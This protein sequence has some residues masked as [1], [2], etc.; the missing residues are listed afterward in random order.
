MKAAG[1]T[2]RPVHFRGDA[3]PEPPCGTLEDRCA[4]SGELEDVTCEGC[5]AALAGDGGDLRTARGEREG[6]SPVA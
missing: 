3:L 4:S 5:L 1:P 2:R 6:D